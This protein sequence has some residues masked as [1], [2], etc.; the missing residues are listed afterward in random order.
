MDADLRRIYEEN[1]DGTKNTH[2]LKNLIIDEVNNTINFY[3]DKNLVKG[4]FKSE[5]GNLIIE[6][7]DGPPNY[8]RQ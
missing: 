7:E 2:E 3:E 8:T 5:D 1:M 4:I 6:L